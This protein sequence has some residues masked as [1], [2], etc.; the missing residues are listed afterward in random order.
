MRRW[1]ASAA[2]LAGA[3][4]L[5]V[6]CGGEVDEDDAGTGPD[7]SASV[8]GGDASSWDAGADAAPTDG[9]AGPLGCGEGPSGT[10]TVPRT[11]EQ[12][13]CFDH[14]ACVMHQLAA[15]G[16]GDYVECGAPEEFTPASSAEACHEE[17]PFGHG[18]E[19]EKRCELLAYAGEL[20]FFCAPDGRRAAVRFS[21]EVS[22]AT[23]GAGAFSY[24]GHDY[25]A[26][27]RGGSGDA[28]RWTWPTEDFGERFV[29]F[30]S[31]EL[32]ETGRVTLQVWFFSGDFTGPMF[33]A[34]GF[35][36]ELPAP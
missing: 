27:S 19:Y 7:A 28:W 18:V 3:C 20:R 22:R 25:Q 30:Q 6:G 10:S 2:L 23:P 17:P 29:G 35:A 11:C 21:G 14:A 31:V 36:A 12:A 33:I 4:A 32:P 13:R 15:Q 1:R 8:D 16:F 9:D 26:G 24:L 5:V 34:G